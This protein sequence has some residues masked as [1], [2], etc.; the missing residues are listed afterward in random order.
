MTYK[1]FTGLLQLNFRCVERISYLTSSDNAINV[2][3]RFRDGGVEGYPLEQSEI[4][5]LQNDF[6][7]FSE[8]HGINGGE[9]EH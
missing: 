4:E 6:L 3:I 2:T 1:T 7:Q 8:K 5:R 9:C